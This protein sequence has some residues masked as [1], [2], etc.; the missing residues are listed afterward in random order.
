[1]SVEYIS[2]KDS[3]APR[4]MK[5]N[6]PLL[7]KKSKQDWIGKLKENPDRSFE[8][9]EYYWQ[10]VHAAIRIIQKYYF[11]DNANTIEKLIFK[12]ARPGTEVTPYIQAVANGTGLRPRQVF[13]FNRETLFLI[14]SEISRYE[15]K[16]RN[17]M[18][19]PD[20]FAFVWLKI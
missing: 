12:F 3:K 10:G 4:G 17:P 13:K 20:L 14:I 6:N 9:F 16:G 1:M 2:Y 8:A 7:V 11:E 18:I 15:L 19:H 5:L